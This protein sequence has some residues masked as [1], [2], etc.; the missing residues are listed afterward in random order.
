MKLR[1]IFD[2]RRWRPGGRARDE[3]DE[4]FQ[5][6]LEQRALDGETAG[7]TADDARRDAERRFG[8]LRYYREQGEKIVKGRA[9]S[10]ARVSL[11]SGVA[12]DI[13]FAIRG[14]RR[15]PGFTVM[16]LLTLSLGIG[17]NAAI[18]SVLNSVI[19]RPLPY[20]NPDR[21][22]QMDE[23]NAERAA[24]AGR[25]YSTT[26]VSAQNY[27][28]YRALNTVF[29]EMGWAVWA[30]N[31]SGVNLRGGDRP[32]RITAVSTS[33]SLFATL[34]VQP[35]LG[36]VW[37]PLEDGFAFSGARVA[38]LSHGIWTSHFGADP[39]V[40][41]R[42]ITVDEWPH[43]VVGVMP[44]DFKLPSVEEE[45]KLRSTLRDADLYVPLW[46][47]AYGL[48]RRGRQFPV[49]ARLREGV[50]I[51]QA[52]AEMNSLAAGLAEAYPESNEGWSV[53]L[54]PLGE[55]LTRSLGP[56]M[57]LMM[58]AVALVLL[59]GCANVANL[60]LARGAVRRSEFALRSALGGGR[61]RIVR[62]LL[63][64]SLVL[65]TA[66]GGI[67]LALAH[68]G[69][70]ALI[71]L[72]PA[73]VPRAGEA[74]IDF[75]VLAF[76]TVVTLGTGVVFGL[77]PAFQISRVDL[78]SAI[79]GARSKR[80]EGR[81]GIGVSRLLVAGEVAM[82]LVLLVGA[83]L[84]TQNFVRLSGADLGYE[85]ENLI[86]VS[87]DVG[88][89]NAYNNRYFTCDLDDT[90]RPLLWNRCP[91]DREAM[92][93]FFGQVV[94]RVTRIPGIQSAALTDIAPLRDLGGY[95]PLRIPGTVTATSPSEGEAGAQVA[96]EEAEVLVGNTSGRVVQPGYF[97]TMGMRMVAGRDFRADDPSGWS[98]VAVINETLAHR[99]WP[100][101]DPLGRRVTFYGGGQWMTVIGVV[102]NAQHTNLS[103]RLK[104]QDEGLESQ[105]YH[106]N[107]SGTMDLIV[108]TSSEPGAFLEPIREAVLELDPGL[109]TGA[110]ATIP[111]LA[112][113]SRALP[114]FHALVVGVFAA[115]AL[116]LTAVGLYGLV[117]YTV[118]RRTSEIGLRMALGATQ[119]KIRRMAM[120]SAAR[121][122]AL[123]VALGAVAPLS[124]A[125]V[126]RSFLF[127]ME[128]MDPVIYL[129]VAG[130]L[131][132]VGVAASY[133][134]AVR[135]S[136][137][138]PTEALRHE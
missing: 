118:G 121:S 79:K 60:L 40:L 86:K 122:V 15:S 30:G 117:A 39:D 73:G 16:A 65:A 54:T 109:P 18:F 115:F 33:A 24:A 4:E 106:L 35:L 52:Q 37:L 5:F 28:D 55:L 44:H 22:V 96:Q 136:R 101:Q 43:T 56:Q 138:S 119:G 104:Y 111:Q 71:S 49:I 126:L 87:L 7:M 93:L 84:L 90:S 2:I 134:P 38:I 125:N 8:D 21:L 88:R 72:V 76:V 95:Y 116:L 14:L 133:V 100:G 135:A 34:G 85:P 36:R 105:V 3:I 50:T 29:E 114:R 75:V 69:N 66:A 89:P 137:L 13:R 6:H 46:Y 68:V 19:L 102:E 51:Q 120:E 63:T 132:G 108:R 83:G 110:V 10:Q 82:A 12:Q 67:G 45:G 123:G 78:A 41:G 127:E 80:A 25:P 9:R 124:L 97:Q 42:T 107:L 62:Q 57:S 92:A 131:A 27:E 98:G 70:R 17:G 94:E 113:A 61:S 26:P 31:P 1:R 129:A 103:D 58:A 32:Y 130:L 59:I 99:V 48:S 23:S 64:E 20:P 91:P 77:V 112:E 74:N 47:N 128:P 11:V 81:G 53:R